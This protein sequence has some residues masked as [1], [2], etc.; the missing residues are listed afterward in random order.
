MVR[1]LALCATVGNVRVAQGVP[2]S[3]GVRRPAVTF[4]ATNGHSPCNKATAGRRT[5]KL[6]DSIN[7]TVPNND[8]F[9][10]QLFGDRADARL[11]GNQRTILL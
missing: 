1:N 10:L 7:M 5:P 2:L 4:R 11:V 3:F 8:N 6:P 9:A